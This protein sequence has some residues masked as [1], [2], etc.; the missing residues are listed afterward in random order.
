MLS[1]RVL[2]EQQARSPSKKFVEELLDQLVYLKN[3]NEKLMKVQ[4]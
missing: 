4:K 1:E 3:E 2:V